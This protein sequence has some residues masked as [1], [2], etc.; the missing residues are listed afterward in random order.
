MCKSGRSAAAPSVSSGG[1]SQQLSQSASVPRRTS[2]GHV[3]RRPLVRFA[4]LLGL[5]CLIAAMIG[6]LMR[7]SG[8]AVHTP[9]V[10]ALLILGAGTIAWTIT[11]ARRSA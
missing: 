8:M 1:V 4:R 7:A 6:I 10:L 5:L 3:G 11:L 2:T 9:S